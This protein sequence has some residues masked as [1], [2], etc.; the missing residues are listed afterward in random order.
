MGR[1]LR[2]NEKRQGR[3]SRSMG[4]R[5]RCPD[6]RRR[7]EDPDSPSARG[8]GRRNLPR[9]RVLEHFSTLRLTHPLERQTGRV[10]NADLAWYAG[11]RFRERSLAAQDVLWAAAGTQ[12]V[13]PSLPQQHFGWR[14]MA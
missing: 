1:V 7:Q 4:D 3:L 12:E 11:L 9:T 10:R 8:R 6:R 5:V 14:G 2:E 13:G